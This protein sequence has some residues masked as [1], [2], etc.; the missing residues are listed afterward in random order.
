MPCIQVDGFLKRGNFEKI[1]SHVKHTLGLAP[2]P[3]PANA[4]YRSENAPCT[5]PVEPV[6][7]RAPRFFAA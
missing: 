7:E 5:I 4:S 1:I 6:G 3:T 2:P